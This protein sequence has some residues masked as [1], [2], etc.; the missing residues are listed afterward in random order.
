MHDDREIQLCNRPR[1]KDSAAVGFYNYFGV[2]HRGTLEDAKRYLGYARKYDS[3]K[4][5]R[6]F[7]VTELVSE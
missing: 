2:V 3:S 5:W 4:E 6:I 7:Q 1:W